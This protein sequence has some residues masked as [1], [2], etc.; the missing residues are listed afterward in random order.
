MITFPLS[1]A[2]RFRQREEGE[3]LEYEYQHA[4]I[5]QEVNDIMKS[6]QVCKDYILFARSSIGPRQRRQCG[7]D[8]Q[9]LALRVEP[10]IESSIVMITTLL[11]VD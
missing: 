10:C 1:K 7:V 5:P 9:R 4:M 3:D 11:V 6:A 8:F 2:V